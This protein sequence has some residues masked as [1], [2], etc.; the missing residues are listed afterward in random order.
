MS[1]CRLN[2]PAFLAAWLDGT[3]SPEVSREVDDHLAEGCPVCWSVL[4]FVDRLRE[5]VGRTGPRADDGPGVP[6]HVL[7]DSDALRRVIGLPTRGATS[8]EIHLAFGPWEARLRI[9]TDP[10]ATGGVL[11]VEAVDRA[12]EEAPQESVAVE[13]RRGDRIVA[14]GVTD[15][16]GRL[17]LPLEGEGPLRLSLRGPG[18]GPTSVPLS[19]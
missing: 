11:R 7:L 17:D 9:S 8:R 2:D 13:V 10:E 14:R 4:R 16:G 12:T 18:V 19:L 5:L 3:L 1:S 15:A 6:A